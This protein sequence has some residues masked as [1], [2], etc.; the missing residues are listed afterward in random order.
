MSK[1]HLSSIVISE[2][3][4]DWWRADAGVVSA[5]AGLLAVIL[6]NDLTRKAQLVSWLTGSSGAGV[7]DGISIRR[8]AIAAVAVEKGDIELVLEKSL[9]QFGD[10]LYIRHTPTMQQEGIAFTFFIPLQNA[11]FVQFT[12]KFYCSLPAMFTGSLRCD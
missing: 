3:D 11:K 5:A 1:H 10:Q 9:L 7:G 8:A 6:G 2:D 12:P 4:L